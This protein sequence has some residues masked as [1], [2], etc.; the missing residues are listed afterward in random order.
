M[1]GNRNRERMGFSVRC[2]V[3]QRLRNYAAR[4]GRPATAILAEWLIAGL[5]LAG[6]P[7]VDR[8]ALL[9]Q[10]RALADK[11][12]DRRNALWKEAFDAG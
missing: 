8:G 7:T 1:P 6:E 12:A 2:E 11:R 3:G 5:E 9:E 4:V 10:R